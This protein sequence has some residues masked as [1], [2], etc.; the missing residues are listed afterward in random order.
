MTKR[1]QRFPVQY[2]KDQSGC[3]WG[4]ISMFDFRHARF[5]RKLIADKRHNNKHAL[6]A[7]LT[8]NKFEALSNLDEEYQG[9]MD[10]GESKRL[11][12]TTDADKLSVKKLIEEEMFIDQDEIKD[13]GNVVESTRTELGSEDSLKTDSKRKRKSRKKSRDMDSNDL[14]ATLKSEVTHNQHSNQQSRDNIDLDKI[15]EDFCQI[16][17]ACSLMHDDD[18]SKVLA[19]SNQKNINSEELARDAIHDFV[20]QMILN[21]KDMVEDKKFLCSHELME[22]LQVISSD[23]E[24]FLK[25][26]QDPNSHLLRYIQELENAQGRSEKEYNSVADSNFSEQDLGNLKQTR[27]IVN[28][29]HHKFFWKKVKS[30]SKVPTNKN[31]KTEVPNRIVILKPAPTKMQ[32]SESENNV[33]SSLDSRD[34]V[35]YKD[36]SVRVGSPF[37]LTEIK[38]KL[39]HAIGKEKHGNHKLPAERQN[40]DSRGKAICKDKTG[41]KSPNKDHFFIEKIARPMFDVVKGTKTGINESGSSKEKVSNLY[42]EAK[43]HLSE[44]LVDNGDDN[45]SISSRQIPKTLGRILSL[46]EYNFSPLGSPGGNLE[47][48]FL[49][50]HARLSTSDKTW[51]VNEDSLSPKQDTYI[52]QPYQ[53]TNNSR[54]QSSVCDKRSNEVPE[55]ESDSTLSHDLDHVDTAEISYPVR[56]EIVAEGNL[57]FTKDIIVLESSSDP[58]CCTAGKDQNHDVSKIAVDAICSECLN[59]DLKENQQS[60]P[61]SSPSHSSITEKMEEL[62]SC[63]DLSGRPSPVSV[64]DIPFSDDDPGYSTCQPVKL[65]IQSLQI[66]FEEQD[67]S[68]LD[69]FH[70]RKS[71]LEENELIYDYINAVFHAASLTQDQLLMK[72]LSSDK[73]LDPS[74]FDQVEF[75]SN[76]LCH[77]QKLLFDCINEVLMEVCWNYFGVSPWVSFVNPSIRPTP[78]MKKIILKVWEGV[79]WHVLP[80]PP[81]HTLEQI[82][83]KDMARNGTWMDLRLD[84]ETVGFE[85]GDVILVELMEDAI[86][87]FVNQS[88][89]S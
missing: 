32:N 69:R 36:P 14:S 41:M 33:V 2:E 19:Q 11:T 25:L 74:L 83:R 60:S 76:M 24:L 22:T 43:K 37:S 4:F 82:V 63:T 51:E 3:M 44:M 50:T 57:E 9:N 88:T 30:Q 66:R 49:T 65:C 53:E 87:S 26:L 48:N 59:G 8:K 47:H 34:I 52:E 54:N 13:Q 89:E 62:E 72:C 73:I 17:R 45:T 58:N 71:C 21:G 27:D 77:E 5:T 35:H 10:R 15:M 39:K 84:A 55:I 80:L 28:R 18:D 64:L 61:L 12:V 56:D 40:N 70:R 75:F 31:V 86:L 42:I 79:C 38:R 23:K 20:N 78:N 67:C 1:S 81:P 68:S 29:K 46:P 85:M 7:V 16:E 6:G